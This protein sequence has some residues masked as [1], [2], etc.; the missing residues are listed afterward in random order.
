[1]NRLSFLVIAIAVS[2]SSKSFAEEPAY[3]EWMEYFHGSW[4]G[5]SSDGKASEVEFKYVPGNYA[6]IGTRP[7]GSGGVQ[8]VGWQ[9]DRKVLVDTEYDANGSYSE[10][11]YSDFGDN[12]MRG[13]FV[14]LWDAE[15]GDLSGATIVVTKEGDDLAS[16]VITGKTK[17][18][19]PV[20]IR[21]K[22]RRKK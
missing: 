3:K 14:H 16:M 13:K 5:Q 7:P 20:E 11:E 2:L 8:L 19:E 17:S 21:G 10:I 22:L 6:M 4:T 9:S 1:M 15:N 12:V 18:G